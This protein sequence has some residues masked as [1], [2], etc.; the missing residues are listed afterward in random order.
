M[1]EVQEVEKE[2]EELQGKLHV[3]EEQRRNVMSNMS[4]E[5]AA[6]V[7]Q[8]THGLQNLYN[9]TNQ[10]IGNV[11]LSG[12]FVSFCCCFLLLICYRCLAFLSLSVSVC[13][14]LLL[15]VTLYHPLSR[16]LFGASH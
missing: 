12:D 16:N 9:T 6:E 2:V 13:C 3:Y 11:L 5:V 7:Q 14:L 1:V 15:Y 8:V 10:A 4:H